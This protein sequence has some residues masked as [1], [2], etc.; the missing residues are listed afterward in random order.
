MLRT[1]LHFM[2]IG[3]GKPKKYANAHAEL[4]S[5]QC[6]KRAV[7][8]DVLIARYKMLNVVGQDICL[9][10][11]Q[12]MSVS[13]ASSTIRSSTANCLHLRVSNSIAA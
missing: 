9:L 7:W 6:V 11:S 10:I 12:G 5:S 13:R 3:F 8:F 1:V 2:V 4:G